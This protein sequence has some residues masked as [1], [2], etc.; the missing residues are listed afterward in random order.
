M[1]HDEIVRLYGPWRSRTVADVAE[2]LRG[3]SGRWWIAGGWAIEAF[4]TVARP[5]GDIDIG[6]ARSD[7]PLLRSHLLGRLD[8]WAADRGDLRPLA[9]TARPIPATCSN[10]WL[11][12][13][14]AEPWDYDVILTDTIIARWTYK[15]DPR[16]S[17]A[18][19]RILWTKDGIEYLRPEVQLLH[20]APGLRPRDQRDFDT[21]LPLL[22]S[23]V[24]DWLED[25]LETAHP[26]H[27]WID[28]LKRSR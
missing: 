23:D 18:L 10:L 5:H 9:D 14:G 13:G 24:S 26:G 22:S 19:D 1:D 15:R 28:A 3:Y 2:L 27:P 17:L 16:V 25:A 20:K 7:A 21:T 12:A 4:T 6:I 11:R 8:V